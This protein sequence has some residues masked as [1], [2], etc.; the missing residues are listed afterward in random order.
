MAEQ[1]FD[2][3][4]IA[5]CQ[6]LS[7]IRLYLEDKNFISALTL[8]GAAEE[9]LGKHCDAQGF[10]SALWSI[11]TNSKMF[12]RALVGNDLTDKELDKLYHGI[13]NR[14][15]NKVKHINPSVEPE[16]VF[17]A[18]EAARDMINRAIDNYWTLGNPLTTEMQL[19]Q[20]TVGRI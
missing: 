7:A 3:S 9:I 19:F 16:M 12:Y 15:R 14:H 13:A 10:P 2:S 1:R 6:L 5:L 20:D 4:D 18:E 17:D 8:S 11:K